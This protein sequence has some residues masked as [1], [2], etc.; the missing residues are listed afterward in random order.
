MNKVKI[1]LYTCED[2]FETDIKTICLKGDT[3][4]GHEQEISGCAKRL[5]DMDSYISIYNKH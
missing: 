5:C 3:L 2:S 1:A 4:Y